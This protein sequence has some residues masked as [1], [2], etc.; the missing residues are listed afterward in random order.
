MSNEKSQTSSEVKATIEVYLSVSDARSAIAFYEK[1]FGATVDQL[2][3]AE[4]GSDRIMHATLKAFG[5]VFH[6]SS[7]FPE[8]DGGDKMGAPSPD[9]PGYTTALI[10]LHSAR[11]LDTAMSRASAAGGTVTMS[12][13]DHEWGARYGRWTD[14]EGHRWAFIS[15]RSDSGSV[16]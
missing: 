7:L 11:E 14:E 12:A 5:T 3:P 16:G 1:A 10:S 8:Y 13:E 15:P 4:D 9:L 6:L 2:F